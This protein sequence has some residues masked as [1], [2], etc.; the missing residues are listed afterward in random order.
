MII[1]SKSNPTIK[2]IIKL[3]DKKYRQ[4]YGKYLVEGTKPVDECLAYGHGAELIVCTEQLAAKYDSPIVVSETL[5]SA[6]SAE[7]TPQGVIAVVKLPD[8]KP[9][10]PDGR[11]LLLDRIRDPG[12]LGTIIRT[13]NAAGYSQL[14]LINCAD[15]FSPKV[16]RA[17]M[18]GIFF[19]KI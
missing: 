7:K 1:N 8:F 12:N 4:Q 19:V 5:F 11:C 17:S 3:Y 10:K 15:P 2:E 13:A 6:I 14:Y 16:V 18:S 9:K